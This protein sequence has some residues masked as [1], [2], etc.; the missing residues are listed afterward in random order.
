M[1]RFKGGRGRGRGR[2]DEDEEFDYRPPVGK[3]KMPLE[4]AGR[5]WA[6]CCKSGTCWQFRWPLQGLLRYNHI[7]QSSCSNAACQ[8]AVLSPPAAAGRPCTCS[9]SSVLFFL[10]PADSPPH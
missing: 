10:R 5:Y 8:T 4:G 1:G 3:R 9:L 2:R 6:T 7:H